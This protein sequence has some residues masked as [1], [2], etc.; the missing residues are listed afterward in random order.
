[1]D[2]FFYVVN[3]A[4]RPEAPHKAMFRYDRAGRAVRWSPPRG[5]VAPTSPVPDVR[6]DDRRN[7]QMVRALLRDP[8]VEVQWIFIQR[9]LAARL[10]QQ[11]ATEGD[12]PAL[13][14]RAT[15]IM[16]QPSDSEPHDD[17]MHVRIY[18]DPKDRSLG[19]LDRGP[20]RW[21]KKRWKYMAPPFGRP[22]DF[23]A[24]AALLGLLR[25][26][27]AVGPDTSRASS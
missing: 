4:G 13:L 12:D 17:H 3:A 8:D 14:A 10:L 22:V 16:R 9:D 7:W 24:A 21:W 6:F 20:E 19:C 18:C 2:I 15:Q 23:D 26:R 11:G 25:G 5:V 27:V 1:M